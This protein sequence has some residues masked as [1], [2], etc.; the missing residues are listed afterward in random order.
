MVEWLE[1]SAYVRMDLGLSLAVFIL[2]GEILSLFFKSVN[3]LR[4]RVQSPLVIQ[5]FKIVLD[6][7]NSN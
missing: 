6:I 7:N 2:F 5:G 3:A 4:K 1:C